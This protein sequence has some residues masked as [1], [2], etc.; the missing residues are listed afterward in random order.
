MKL[1]FKKEMLMSFLAVLL[2]EESLL[3]S[4][5]HLQDIRQ[6]SQR[7]NHRGN[8]D[9]LHD[10]QFALFYHILHT[11]EKCYYF[12][13]V[14]YVLIFDGAIT[15]KQEIYKLLQEKGYILKGKSDHELLAKLFAY[16]KTDCFSLLQGSFIILIWDTVEK[17]HFGARDPFGK[18]Q[19]Y[20]TESAEETILTTEKKSALFSY[21]EDTFDDYAF[22]HYIDYGY[23]P[24]PHTL[25]KGIKQVNKGHYFIKRLGDPLTFIRYCQMSFPKRSPKKDD[26]ISHGRFAFHQSVAARVY[27]QQR[28]G[29]I[30]DHH[31][32][33]LALAQ[34]AKQYDE[35]IT[36]FSVHTTEKDCFAQKVADELSLTHRQIEVTPEQFMKEMPKIVWLLDSPF[37]SLHVVSKYFIAKYAQEKVDALVSTAGS[38]VMTGYF[39]PETG[40]S[41]RRF[42]P[43]FLFRN[44]RK[45]LMRKPLFTKSFKQRLL[46][47]IVTVHPDYE[48]Y[49]RQKNQWDEVTQYQYAKMNSTLPSN[50]LNY[51]EQLISAHQLSLHTPFLDEGLFERLQYLSL[52]EKRSN[53]FVQ[54]VILERFSKA[55]LKSVQDT[56]LSEHEPLPISDWLRGE[57]YEWAGDLV[58]TSNF[59]EFMDKEVV[60][61]MLE[62]H[63][64]KPMRDILPLWTV[65][66][67][68]LWYSVYEDG[69]VSYE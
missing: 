54:D 12:S 58:T 15:N 38:E 25:T 44:S 52:A 17:V 36:I 29:I 64:E 56:L 19:L 49:M 69:Y 41:Q 62:N 14:R 5:E 67:F 53:Q 63:R 23:V 21:Y 10:K 28:N 60:L 59:A 18:K 51:L 48:L 40:R 68:I 31:L 55:K 27:L 33:S 57:C 16:K 26:V 9:L 61:Q 2:Q 46:G 35:Q 43:K 65:I 24:E 13:E 34:T 6:M 50:E 39:N 20:Y 42:L 30:C 37:A 4:K 1:R 45:S 3:F 11:V 47:R 8:S 32:A 22:H 7:M 66:V